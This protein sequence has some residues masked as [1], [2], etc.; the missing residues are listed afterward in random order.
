MVDCGAVDWLLPQRTDQARQS[1][2]Q[3]EVCGVHHHLRSRP[4]ARS[5]AAGAAVALCGGPAH[6][7]SH[8][9]AGAALLR[10]VRRG[11]SQPGRGAAAYHR[12]VE[13]RIQMREGDCAYSLYRE[14]ADEY[15]AAFG[16]AGVRFLFE[17]KSAGGS[18]PL[19]PGQGTP[20]GRILQASN[21]DV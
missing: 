11:P 17:R 6:G 7:R 13:V 1:H 4:D 14:A 15:L 12:A 20:P 16:S 8:A 19:E 2:E 5:T 21:A 10:H 3:S 9:S 18:S